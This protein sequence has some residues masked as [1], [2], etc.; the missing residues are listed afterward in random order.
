ML[1]PGIGAHPNDPTHR[2]VASLESPLA[3][4]FR[5]SRLVGRCPKCRYAHLRIH[6]GGPFEP[7]AMVLVEASTTLKIRRDDQLQANVLSGSGCEACECP[8][9]DRQ[10]LQQSSAILADGVGHPPAELV[11]NTV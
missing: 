3:K 7:C 6:F 8:A 9:V 2:R 4:T 5:N 10:W 1:A 11:L